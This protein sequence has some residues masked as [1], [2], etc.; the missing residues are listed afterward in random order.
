MVIRSAQDLYDIVVKGGQPTIVQRAQ[1]RIVAASAVAGLVDA[2]GLLMSVNGASA[3][4]NSS[5]FQRP[6][7]DLQTGARHPLFHLA[8]WREAYGRLLVG[9]TDPITTIL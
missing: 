8:L 7:R 3:F 5:I 9:V 6:W 2:A 1:Q 4:A